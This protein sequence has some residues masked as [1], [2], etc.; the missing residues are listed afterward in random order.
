MAN[1]KFRRGTGNLPA[2]TEDGTFYL[3]TEEQQLYVGDGEAGYQL[4][5][6]NPNALTID[7][8][9]TSSKWDGSEAASLEF[10]QSTNNGNIQ[11]NNK[12]IPVYQLPP[13]Y[14]EYLA[15]QTYKTPTIASFTMIGTNGSALGTSKE[16]GATINAV[17]FS[18]NET[19]ISNISGQLGFYFGSTLKESVMPVSSL[20]TCNLTEA[21]EQTLTSAVTFKL[22]G[23]DSRGN[24]LSKTYSISVNKYAY[25][26]A[27]ANTTIPEKTALTKRTSN[28]TAG[29]YKIT[30]NQQYGWLVT[31]SAITK[32]TWNGNTLEEGESGDYTYRG[33]K[34]YTLDT[35]ATLTYYVYMFNGSKTGTF[36]YVVS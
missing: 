36:E 26:G 18:H 22:Q 10:E 4:K 5:A 8:F 6:P 24:A 23:T 12:D 11:I 30:M 17:K 2:K 32:I 20:T 15:K 34:T 9:G 14:E 16:Y 7:I 13:E 19:N 28:G 3:N 35:G 27:T 33:T 25:Y 21:I 29:T 1:V 31:P